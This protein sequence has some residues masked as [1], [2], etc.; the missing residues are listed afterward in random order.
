MVQNEKRTWLGCVC[1]CVGILILYGLSVFRMYA[2]HAFSEPVV[3][4]ASFCLAL[5]SFCYMGYCIYFFYGMH[6][7]KWLAGVAIYDV[8]MLAISLAVTLLPLPS[9]LRVVL[10][11]LLA[12]YRGVLFLTARMD[13]KWTGLI[14]GFLFLISECVALRLYTKQKVKQT[15][16]KVR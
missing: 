9:G 15:K 10:S 8:V 16:E 2:D 3:T 6:S 12:P 5:A 7:E 14:L 11:W 4:V 13:L 1:L